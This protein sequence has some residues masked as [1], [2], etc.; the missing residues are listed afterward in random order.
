MIFNQFILANDG[1][2]HTETSPDVELSKVRSF[3]KQHELF[4]ILH[5]E[6][7]DHYS[8]LYLAGFLK[9]VGYTLK[10]IC[11]II[12][13]EAAWTDYDAKVTWL[14][15]RS[16]WKGKKAF[17]D[18]FAE[19]VSGENTFTK[20]VSPGVPECSIKYTSCTDCKHKC[21]VWGVSHG[22]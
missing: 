5:S 14:H 13:A 11:A 1:D 17:L 19:G 10:E 12:D 8:R 21:P 22:L 15:V 2:I 16:L 9:Y 18:G 7:P 3:H 4:N 6:D 20:V